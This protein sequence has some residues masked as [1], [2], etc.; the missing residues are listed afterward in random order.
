MDRFVARIRANLTP[1]Q[2]ALAVSRRNVFYEELHPET[3]AGFA[4]GLAR[5]S[6]ATANSDSDKA[7]AGSTGQTERDVRRAAARDCLWAD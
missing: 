5:H 1:A 2:E 3:K 6:P 7:T 4:G